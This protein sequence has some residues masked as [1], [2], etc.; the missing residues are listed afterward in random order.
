MFECNDGEDQYSRLFFRFDFQVL[1]VPHFV[2]A[3]EMC[4]IGQTL[5]G[6]DAE[7]TLRTNLDPD[8]EKHCAVRRQR[9][10]R[11]DGVDPKQSQ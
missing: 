9:R 3:A 11:W 10:Q 7:K 2:V 8:R 4:E 1:P 5:A 6:M